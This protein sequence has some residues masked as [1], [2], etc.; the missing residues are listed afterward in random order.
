ML[1]RRRL[2]EKSENHS[3]MCVEGKICRSLSICFNRMETIVDS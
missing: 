3:I 2:N 1:A